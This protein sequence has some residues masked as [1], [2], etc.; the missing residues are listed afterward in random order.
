MSAVNYYVAS[1]MLY[2]EGWVQLPDYAARSIVL[3]CGTRGPCKA[4]NTPGIQL[5]AVR[6]VLAVDAH[7]GDRNRELYERRVA[8]REGR[9]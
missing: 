7:G 3:D 4:C 2:S 9:L 8:A 5:A 6:A 1:T